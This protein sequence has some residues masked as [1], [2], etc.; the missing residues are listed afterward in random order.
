MKYLILMFFV[1]ILFLS[2]CAVSSEVGAEKQ[3]ERSGSQPE[4]LNKPTS[5]ADESVLFTGEFTQAKDRAFGMN[6]AYADGLRKLMNSMQVAVKTQSSL[7]M[8]GNNMNEDDIAK[9]SEFSVAWIS[10]TKNV[11]GVKNPDSYW[12]KIEKKTVSGVTY[13]YNCYSLLKISKLDYNKSLEG[14]YNEMKKKAQ[15]ANNLEAQRVAEKLMEDLKK[16]SGNR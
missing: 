13:F 7:V 11:A 16:E 4:W 6:Q 10:D 9:F 3:I 14:A 5:E 1:S 12:E 15:E 2:G 8:R